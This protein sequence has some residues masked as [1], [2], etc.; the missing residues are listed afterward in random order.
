MSRL[1]SESCVDYSRISVISDAGHCTLRLFFFNHSQA[2]SEVVQIFRVKNLL[3]HDVPVLTIVKQT[4]Q[5]NS[6][7]DLTL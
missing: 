7:A 2:F 4:S 5:V 3:N 1:Q 6:L